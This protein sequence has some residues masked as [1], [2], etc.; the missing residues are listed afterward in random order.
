M[1][2]FRKLRSLVIFTKDSE[3]LEG[4]NELYKL[5]KR[6]AF[7]VKAGAIFKKIKIDGCVN[8]AQ[9]RQFLLEKS[10][11]LTSGSSQPLVL[12]GME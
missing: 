11:I 1:I 2:S 3:L 5:L 12:T 9:T 10:L 4:R 6:F 8:R 7:T